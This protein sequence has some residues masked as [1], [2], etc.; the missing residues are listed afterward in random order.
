MSGMLA[1]GLNKSRGWD[2]VTNAAVFDGASVQFTRQTNKRFGFENPSSLARAPAVDKSNGNQ[3]RHTS[4]Y[5]MRQIFDGRSHKTKLSLASVT[6]GYAI[7]KNFTLVKRSSRRVFSS[8]N[9]LP[10]LWIPAKKFR[11]ENRPRLI[12]CYN[13][14]SFPRGRFILEK[15]RR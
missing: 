4:W 13:R 1:R 10:K 6:A 3:S 8:I 12:K 15:K 11:S 9:Y 5:G 2:S 7:R 14:R